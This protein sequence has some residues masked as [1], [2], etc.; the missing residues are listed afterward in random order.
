M[1]WGTELPLV[2]RL[3]LGGGLDRKAQPEEGE[4]WAS[5]SLTAL[6]AQQKPTYPHAG[7]MQL[8]FLTGL[9]DVNVAKA[10]AVSDELLIPCRLEL[11]NYWV[12][13]SVAVPLTSP[14]VAV[15]VT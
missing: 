14:E 8:S 4:G 10:A 15:I 1:S 3:S 11:N 12:T 2:Q 5:W 9:R 7:L 13:T 6:P